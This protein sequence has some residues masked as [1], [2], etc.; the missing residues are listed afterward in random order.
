MPLFFFF[1]LVSNL[2][3]FAKK[4]VRYLEALAK[5]GDDTK[6]ALKE[7]EKAKEMVAKRS[8][9]SVSR[10]LSKGNDELP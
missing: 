4:Y 5:F 10:T 9:R 2:E 6:V 1:S 8:D 3:L 7:N